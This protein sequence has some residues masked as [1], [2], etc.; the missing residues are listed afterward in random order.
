MFRGDPQHTGFYQTEE[1]ERL[2]GVL[3]QF[4][5][6]GPVRSSPAISGDKVFVGSTDGK[7]YALERETGLESWQVDVFSPV[8]SSPAIAQGIVVFGSRDGSFHAVDARS[9]DP[10]WQVRTGDLLPWEWGFEGWDVYTASPV[11]VDS[12]VIFGAGDGVVYAVDIRTGE[13]LWQFVTAGRIRSTPAVD[14]GVVYVGSADGLAYA[15]ELGT[16]NEV[17]RFETDGHSMVSEEHGVDRKSII[18][19]PAVENEN[20]YVGSRDGFL[21]VLDRETG[22]ERLRISHE[23]SW[24]M[25]SPAIL[26]RVVYAGTSDGRFVHAVDAASGDE[27]WRF[28]GEGYTWSSPAVTQN[29]VYI[30]DGGGYLR[31]VALGSGE[32]RWSFKVG[33]GVYSSPVVDDG[34][35]FFGAD[36]GNVYALHGNGQYAHRAVYWDAEFADMMYF[37]SHTETKVYFEQIGYQVL[38]A[39]DLASFLE[40]RISDGEPSVVVF[41][42][43]YFPSE[44]GAEPSDTVLFNRYLH[45]GGKV[46]WLDIP[47]MALQRNEEGRITLFDR[48]RTA[49]LLGVD[50]SDF[51]FDFYATHPTE[52]GQ[53]WGLNRGWV[54]SYSIAVSD[55]IQVL[56]LDETG[57][58]GAWV[59]NY[60]GPPGTGYI[61]VGMD[62]ASEAAL[63]A[64]LAL[65]NFGLYEGRDKSR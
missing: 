54:S 7:L 12:T 58:A 56:A 22:A 18:A 28:V 11:V 25:S 43:G 49:E 48:N 24:A 13:E 6:G 63:E 40:S 3:W 53:T 64:V 39:N 30:G 51:N 17:W 35:V 27:L 1:V 34:I 42:M 37:R 21:Y 9:G 26:D 2:G 44:V 29:T 47:P 10:V 41:A 16:G 19:S 50:H 65:A 5:T 59:K 31:A 33:D 38:G 15:L 8:S 57:R 61:G 4:E 45:A 14:A 32:E 20:V 23:G 55:S 52:L 62:H 60:G 36:D 46:V